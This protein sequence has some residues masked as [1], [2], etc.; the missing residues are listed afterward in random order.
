M[1]GRYIIMNFPTNSKYEI[2]N[3]RRVKEAFSEVL[4]NSET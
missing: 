2:K 4:G 3:G 1:M